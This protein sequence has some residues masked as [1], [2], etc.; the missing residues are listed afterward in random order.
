M[1]DLEMNGKNN[2]LNF[3]NI[4][5]AIVTHPTQFIMIYIV[6]TGRDLKNIWSGVLHGRP[7]TMASISK[8]Y[9]N[10]SKTK[11]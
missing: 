9:I 10:L 7:R 2:E 4:Q 8:H 6:H 5:L 11:T 3:Q 1:Y